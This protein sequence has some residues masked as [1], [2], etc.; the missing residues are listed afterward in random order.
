MKYIILYCAIPLAL[1][2]CGNK[3]VISPEVITQQ[4]EH[5]TDDPAIWIHP[6]DPFKSLIIGTD[7]DSQGALYAFD[8][9]G[10]IV[11]KTETLQRPNNVDVAYNFPINDSTVIDIA[12]AT[13]R[14]KNTI[15]VFS[16]PDMHPLDGGGIPVFEGEDQRSPMGISLYTRTDTLGR[17]E[18]FAVVGRKDGPS[19]SY[20]YQYLLQTDT[21]GMITGRL[22]RKFGNYSGTK[23]IEAIAVD[24]ELGYIYYSDERSG[25]R[26]YYAD[27]EKGNEELALFGTT[28]FK[29][30]REGIS[31]YKKDDHNGYILVSN[32]SNNS[33]KV[34]PR[35]GLN[36]NPHNHPEIAEIPVKA[37]ESD[38]NEVV[39]FDLGEPF[40][41]GI[42]V[43]MSD[44][45]T[46]HYYDWRKFQ[47]IIDQAESQSASPQ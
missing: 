28:G 10:N 15:R 7:K 5:D 45:K 31:I 34:F 12:V 20:L 29:E 6:E 1:A 9:Q 24:N 4:V 32:Q 13:E 16:L 17:N 2:S 37:V 27:P 35:E 18:I 25:I 30:D 46:F 33:F 42:F 8:L 3:N 22:V 36:A 19:G 47:K 21:T 23:E 39:N 41:A 44:D 26:K 14:E 11:H 43:A 38:G 40:S